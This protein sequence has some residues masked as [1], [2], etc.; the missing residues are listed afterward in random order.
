MKSFSYNPFFK[1]P[2]NSLRARY[3]KLSL[4]DTSFF[5]LIAKTLKG[6]F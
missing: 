5:I 4:V 2:P 3:E 6:I 1:N